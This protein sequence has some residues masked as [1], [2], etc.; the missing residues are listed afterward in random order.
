M[1]ISHLAV[2][3]IKFHSTKIPFLSL[4]VE[5]TTTPCKSAVMQNKTMHRGRCSLCAFK[6]TS[7]IF[8]ILNTTEMYIAL[9]HFLSAVEEYLD[10]VSLNDSSPPVRST[11]ISLLW[12]CLSALWHC[13]W[14][15]TS[16][17][18][19]PMR[20]HWIQCVRRADLRSTWVK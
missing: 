6:W 13:K 7:L 11:E 18:W 19:Y 14:T 3:G 4:S 17:F 10:R 1:I 12:T 16:L 5:C 8:V 2:I 9:F 15:V 20:K